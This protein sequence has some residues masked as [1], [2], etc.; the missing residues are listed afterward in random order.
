MPSRL[1]TSLALA[2]ALTATAAAQEPKLPDARTFDKLVSDS[3]RDVHDKGATIYNDEKDF[4]GTFRLYQGALA[5]VRPL[6]AHRPEAQK[7]IDTG[8]AAADKV[9][10]AEGKPD[11]ARKAF[12]LHETIEAVR[13]ELK[14]GFTA[15]KPPEKKPEEK[16]VVDPPKKP[17]DPPKKPIDPPKKPNDK[18]SGTV[19]LQGKPLAEGEVTVVTLGAPVPRTFTATVKDGKYAFAEALPAG[20]Y[21]VIVT[22]K[23]VPEKY[24][25]T[26]SSALRF[27]VAAGAANFDIALQ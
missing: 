27:D 6:L 7:L 23:G 14:A 17:V 5:T 16:K 13:K 9:P 26:N 8:F 20:K 25:L 4:A 21:V 1:C 18:L 3:L 12:V 19:T 22:G 2:L 15:P 10:D 11:F 24:T